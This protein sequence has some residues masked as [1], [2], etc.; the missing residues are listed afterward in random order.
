[1]GIQGKS[2]LAK[3]IE[4]WHVIHPF[5]ESLL[6][7]DGYTLSV[8]DEKTLCYLEHG[9]IVSREIIFMPP[10]YVGHMTGK[11]KYGRMGL[12]VLNSAK[13]HSG[14]VGRIV[15]ELVNLNNK[16]DSITLPVGEPAVHLEFANRDGTPSVYNG[17]GYQFQY[18]TDE[19]VSLFKR[20]MLENFP[21]AY[22]KDLVEKQAEKRLRPDHVA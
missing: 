6:D 1:M 21:D 8:R 14:Y 22:D 4:K 12:S 13:A 16:R 19:E 17:I 10:N 15:L 2:E 11:I 18:M 5:D 20:I 7:G 9:N 3:M